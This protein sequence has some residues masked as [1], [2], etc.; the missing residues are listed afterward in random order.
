MNQVE[1]VSLVTGGGTGIGRAIAA[2]LARQGPVV[3]V[4][5]RPDVLQATAAELGERVFAIQ[6]D[7]SRQVDVQAL[8]TRIR[9]GWGRVDILVNNAGFLRGVTL[10]EG[11]AGEAGFD[12]V[13]GTN[14]KGTY[15]VT[16]APW[17]TCS[18]VLEVGSSTSAPSLPSQGVAGRARPRPMPQPRRACSGSASGWHGSSGHRASRSTPSPPGSSRVPSSHSPFRR[19]GPAG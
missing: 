1:R 17:R 6:A 15:L 10:A 9:D 14:L 3:I 19:H 5:R 8:A 7:V 11:E 16:A 13:I 2:R 18:L 4:G 12:E